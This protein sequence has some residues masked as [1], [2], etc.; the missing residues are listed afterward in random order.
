MEVLGAAV[1]EEDEVVAGRGD[2][3]CVEEGRHGG[4]GYAGD[5]DNVSGEEVV[6]GDP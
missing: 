3:R 4:A 6:G 1:V 5:A 2:G